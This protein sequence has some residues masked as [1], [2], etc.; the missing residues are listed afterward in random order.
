M[1]QVAV[2]AKGL[3]V[4]EA[5]K[6]GGEVLPGA[7]KHC[8]VLILVFVLLVVFRWLSLCREVALEV[9]MLVLSAEIS[10]P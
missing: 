8:L 9:V 6:N 10:V 2:R 4:R 5:N 1:L 7:E 3:I